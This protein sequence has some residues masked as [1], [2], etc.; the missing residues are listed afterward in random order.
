MVAWEHVRVGDAVLDL[1]F[2]VVLVVG[3]CFLHLHVIVTTRIILT[4]VRHTHIFT[5][6]VRRFG[7]LSQRESSLKLLSVWSSVKEE[8]GTTWHYL[9]CAVIR[10]LC[11]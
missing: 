8:P 10:V 11:C 9:S 7:G 4:A 1:I 5:G 2:G 3:G 6:E